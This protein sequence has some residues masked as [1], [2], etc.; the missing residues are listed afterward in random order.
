MPGPYSIRNPGCAIIW[1]SL[2]AGGAS[3]VV[4]VGEQSRLTSTVAVSQLLPVAEDQAR[5]AR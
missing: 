1:L 2:E 4:G 5:T 3:E